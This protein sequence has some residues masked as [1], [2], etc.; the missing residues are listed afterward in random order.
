MGR[1][2]GH[3]ADY[4]YGLQHTI[5]YKTVRR[6]GAMNGGHRVGVQNLRCGPTP[7]PITRKQKPRMTVEGWFVEANRH[8]AHVNLA[9]KLEDNPLQKPALRV[10]PARKTRHGSLLK[11]GLLRRNRYA[12]HVYLA[13]KTIPSRYSTSPDPPMTVLI[14]PSPL[15]LSIW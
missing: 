1:T 12:A 7:A 6:N 11:A 9:L 10:D 15:I 13:L 3:A 8:A 14:E 5:C 4:H 2:N